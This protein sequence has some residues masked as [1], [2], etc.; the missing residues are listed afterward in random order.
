MALKCH[1]RGSMDGEVSSGGR[2]GSSK[3]VEV[4]LG[5]GDNMAV[6]LRGL[7]GRDELPVEGEGD[8]AL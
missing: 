5:I 1:C 2:W 6:P 4:G 3:T 7:A 8:S